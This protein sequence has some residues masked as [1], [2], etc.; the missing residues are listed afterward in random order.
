VELQGTVRA[1]VV[2]GNPV[3]MTAKVSLHK[4]VNF[5]VRDVTWASPQSVEASTMR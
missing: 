1:D 5:A 3:L 4:G 2:V